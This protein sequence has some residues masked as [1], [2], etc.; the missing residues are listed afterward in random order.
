MNLKAFGGTR[1]LSDSIFYGISN[2][3]QKSF[4]FLIV[5]FLSKNLT[6]ENYGII[7]FILTL[8]SLST[9]LIIFGQ[10]YAVARYFD[11]KSNKERKKTIISQSLTIHLIQVIFFLPFM[12]GII[13]FLKKKN[14]IPEDNLD[15]IILTSLTIFS[16][17]IINFCQVILRY[18]FERVKFFFINC[19]QGL[20][21]FICIVYLIKYSNLNIEKILSFY[22][23]TNIFILFI[24]IFFIKKWLIFPKKKWINNQLIKYGFSFG[25]ISLLTSLSMM[26]ERYF[27]MEYVNTYY[28]GIYSL[29]LKVGMIAQIIMH[30]I[31]SGWEPYLISNL[32]NK[33]INRNLNLMLKITIFASLFLA[34]FLNLIGEYIILFLGNENYLEAKYYILPISLGVIFQELYRIPL[35]GIIESKKAHVFTVI[36]FMCFF[37]LVLTLFML[38]DLIDL[39][40]IVLVISFVYFFR[41]F[42]LSFISNYISKL[43][44]N[45]LDLILILTIYIILFLVIYHFDVFNFNEFLK[46]TMMLIL[47]GITLTF[48]INLS[49]IKI[50]KKVMIN[51]FR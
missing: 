46:F 31:L 44:L 32:N 17:V 33:N 23:I 19:I 4:A 41:F 36:Q 16:L 14:I 26:Y 5:F 39:K 24:A 11:H 49:E 35:S 18:S 22:F 28:L 27:I 15:I 10:D 9:I 34:F 48:F 29:A 6:V 1:L 13:F 25:L 8:I 3:F 7:D 12:L 45:I 42:S 47:S 43:K 37:I 40:I 51:F 21:F 50:I 38:K 20:L 2:I 30:S